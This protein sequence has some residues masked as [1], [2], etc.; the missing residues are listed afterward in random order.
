MT[1]TIEDHLEF[2]KE[3]KVRRKKSGLTQT[4]LGRLM[5]YTTDSVAK[6]M[7]SRWETGKRSPKIGSLMLMN[8]IIDKNTKAK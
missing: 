6:N 4:K 7:I 8:D 3:L 1:T 2:L 5:G